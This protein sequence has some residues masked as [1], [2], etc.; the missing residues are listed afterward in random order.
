MAE[1]D[2][3]KD[4]PWPKCIHMTFDAAKAN[5]FPGYGA[6]TFFGPFTKLF[7]HLF[8]IDGPYFIDPQFKS[9]APRGSQERADFVPVLLVKVKQRPVFFL[10]IEHPSSLPSQSKREEADE[11]MRCKFRD[12]GLKTTIPTLYGV[13]AFGTHLSFYQYDLATGDI[14]P[15]KI[16]GPDASEIAPMS[17]WDYDVLQQ[18]EADRLRDVITRAMEMCAHL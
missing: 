10:E 13:S 6:A 14:H 4:R 12:L 3:P 1:A 11:Q 15:S 7:Y 16:L 17:H 2:H 9:E 5:D 18:E 8:S